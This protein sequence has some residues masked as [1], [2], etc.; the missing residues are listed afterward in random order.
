MLP[1]YLWTFMLCFGLSGPLSSYAEAPS[2]L[3]TL[4]RSN[5]ARWAHYGPF[6]QTGL[7]RRDQDTDI[8]RG[9]T[10]QGHGEDASLQAEERGF[11]RSWD[12]WPPEL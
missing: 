4:C 1:I 2:I 10:V 12:L 8:Q 9:T 5:Q 6:N 7:V 3:A 11:R